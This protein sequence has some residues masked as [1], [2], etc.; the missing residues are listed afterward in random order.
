MFEGTILHTKCGLLL[1]QVVQGRLGAPGLDFQ[2][3]DRHVQFG[4]IAVACNYPQEAHTEGGVGSLTSRK[5]LQLFL[6][7]ARTDVTS[8]ANMRKCCTKTRLIAP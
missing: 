1:T 7:A 4:S 6:P 8:R 3:R 2:T 5:Y